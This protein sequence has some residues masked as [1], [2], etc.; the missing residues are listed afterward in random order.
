MR[1]TSKNPKE[2][3]TQSSLSLMKNKARLSTMTAFFIGYHLKHLN[4]DLL[5]PFKQASF[6][7]FLL[8]STAKNETSNLS[9]APTIM[10]LHKGYSSQTSPEGGIVLFR[11]LVSV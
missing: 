10:I 5:N 4:I 8:R 11:L 6:M 1:N 7:V 3:L 2:T 9:L